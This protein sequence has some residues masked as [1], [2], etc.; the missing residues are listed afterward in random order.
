MDGVRVRQP[1]RREQVA[2][3]GHP[4]LRSLAIERAMI[5]PAFRVT[6]LELDSTRGS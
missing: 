1:S 2:M 3:L 5:G 4:T 6:V